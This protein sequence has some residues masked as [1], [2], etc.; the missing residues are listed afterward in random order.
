MKTV[1]N[2]FGLVLMTMTVVLVGGC[3]GPSAGE[4]RE[5][6]YSASAGEVAE[7]NISVRDRDI[8]ILPSSDD[9][10]YLTYFESDKEF[11]KIDLDENKVLSMQSASD[12]EMS[13]FFGLSDGSM[14]VIRLEVPD[15]LPCNLVISSTKEDIELTN[16]TV[17]G[18][19]DIQINDGAI[20]LDQFS[21]QGDIILN[22]K[23]G[24]ISGTI[25][26]SYEDFNIQSKAH[27]GENNLPENKEGGTKELSVNT[28][29]GDIEIEIVNHK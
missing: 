16:I 19:V 10:I 14:Q 22:A 26:G 3:S 4:V 27:K 5:K 13:D 15:P 7:I 29:N 18:N 17:E 8:E 12:K 25:D 6:Q 24:D 11:Y 21:V 23:N 28:N 1:K 9:K 20:E 2:Y